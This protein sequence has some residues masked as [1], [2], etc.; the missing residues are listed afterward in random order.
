MRV[1]NTQLGAAYVAPLSVVAL[2]DK[3][4]QKIEGVRVDGSRLAHF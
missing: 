3:T 2:F 4:S 1:L